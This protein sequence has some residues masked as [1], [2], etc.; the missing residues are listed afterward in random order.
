[1]EHT[2]TKPK[3]LQGYEV[4]RMVAGLTG[5][6]AALHLDRGESLIIRTDAPLPAGRLVGFSL[7]ACVSIKN[8]GHHRYFPLKDYKSR[9]AWLT[10]KGIQ[11]GFEL[12][13]AYSYSKKFTVKK[14]ARS[15]TVDDTMFTG[16]L[17]VTDE[18]KFNSCLLSGIGNNARSFGFGMLVV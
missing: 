11:H 4:H 9:Y 7:R 14:P 1:M 10:H 3:S 2:I 8:N 17:K 6:E 13:T 12:I 5:G 15:F 18:D 16:V